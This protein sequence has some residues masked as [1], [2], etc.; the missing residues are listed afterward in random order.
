SALAIIATVALGVVLLFRALPWS[1]PGPWPLVGLIVSVGATGVL[2]VQADSLINGTPIDLRVQ[3]ALLAV[4]ASLAAGAEVFYSRR[5]AVDAGLASLEAMQR[6]LMA[7]LPNPVLIADKD[8]RVTTVNRAGLEMFGQRAPGQLITS[9]L[10]FVA[11]PNAPGLVRAWRGPITD[12]RGRVIDAEVQLSVVLR[13]G[14]ASAVYVVND[15]SELATT[16]RLREQL[17]Y[18]V[19]HELR[20]PLTVLDNT[21]DIISREYV[22]L[23]SSE[24]EQLLASSRRTVRRLRSLMDQLLSAGTIESGRFILELRPISLRAIVEDAVD[25][26]RPDVEG[27]DQHVAVEIEEHTTVMADARYA[28][29]VLAN[30]LAN[31]SKYGPRTQGIHVTA[32]RDGRV[33][34]VSVTDHGPGI[35]S[36]QQADLFKRFYRLAST[37]AEPGVGLGLAIAKGVVEAHGGHMGVVSEAGKGTTVWFTLRLAEF[38]AV[39]AA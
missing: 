18:S 6:D 30:L 31:A 1:R 28:Q 8:G 24:F 33:V 10:P 13:A 21:L 37:S 20:Q 14:D 39:G 38:P 11:P 26:A 22:S 16:N 5:R 27:R 36:E 4:A 25:A 17:L 23:S 29:Q 15:V 9:I 7:S 35:P 19:A 32:V 2:V 3:L 12:P 34:R